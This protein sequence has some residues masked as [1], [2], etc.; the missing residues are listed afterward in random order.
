MRFGFY[1]LLND[2]TYEFISFCE[3]EAAKWLAMHASDF[4]ELLDKY[5]PEGKRK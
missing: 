5:V 1:R 4:Q 2:G 3:P